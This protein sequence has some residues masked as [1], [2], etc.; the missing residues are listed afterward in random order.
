MQAVVNEETDPAVLVARLQQRVVELQSELAL[1][2]SG[3]DVA[4]TGPLT[5]AELDRCREVSG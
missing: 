4:S 1:A 3:T 5:P 2:T